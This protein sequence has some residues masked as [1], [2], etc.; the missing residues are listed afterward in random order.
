MKKIIVAALALGSFYASANCNV[1][2]GGKVS[3]KVKVALLDMNYDLVSSIENDQVDYVVTEKDG[4]CISGYFGVCNHM[5]N[6]DKDETEIT[7][8]KAYIVDGELVKKNLISARSATLYNP[9]GHLP[10]ISFG[11]HWEKAEN[12][13]ISKLEKLGECEKN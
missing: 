13:F 7:L 6:Y 9:H 12:K 4:G 10:R 8:S 2:L 5:G 1:L 3:D 11:K